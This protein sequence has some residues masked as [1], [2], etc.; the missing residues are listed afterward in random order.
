MENPIRQHT[1]E[2]H[3]KD[4]LTTGRCQFITTLFRPVYEDLRIFSL[5]NWEGRDSLFKSNFLIT[6]GNAFINRFYNKKQVSFVYSL[7]VLG[8][9]PGDPVMLILR[10]KQLT[11]VTLEM[12]KIDF[13]KDFHRF[14]QA[15]G[16]F[17]VYY[18][19]FPCLLYTSPSPR[20][21]LLA[22]KPSSA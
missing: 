18:L 12:G 22:R 13:R 1:M 10:V 8:N 4:E 15:Y 14:Q 20:D 17:D 6:Q 2:I 5:E 9:H 3:E 16:L 19:A 11:V 21:G 7:A